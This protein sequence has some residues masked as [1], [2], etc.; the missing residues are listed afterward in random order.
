MGFM[1]QMLIGR[2]DR[3]PQHLFLVSVYCDPNPNTVSERSLPVIRAE[4][5][6]GSAVMGIQFPTVLAP[7]LKVPRCASCD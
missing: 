6:D 3:I 7:N 5:D 1:R 2:G 4:L